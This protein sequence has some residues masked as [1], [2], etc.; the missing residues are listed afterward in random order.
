MESRFGKILQ[1]SSSLF[2]AESLPLLFKWD[3][4]VGL[5][6]IPKCTHSN[7]MHDGKIYPIISLLLRMYR[8]WPMHS[9]LL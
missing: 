7:T 3:L 6:Q 5:L 9:S 2:A 1:Y 8:R 4:L